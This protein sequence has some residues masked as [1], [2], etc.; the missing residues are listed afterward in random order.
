MDSIISVLVSRKSLYTQVVAV[1]KI[2][3]TD[4]DTFYPYAVTL[5]K[6]VVIRIKDEKLGREIDIINKIILGDV[7][8]VREETIAGQNVRKGIFKMEKTLPIKK[9]TPEYISELQKDIGEIKESDV[10]LNLEDLMYRLANYLSPV[11]TSSL[12]L[13]ATPVFIIPEG[14][15]EG[16]LV[17]FVQVLTLLYED[18]NNEIPLKIMYFEDYRMPTIWIDYIPRDEF[19][20]YLT[21]GANMKKNVELFET[22][23][24]NVA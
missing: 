6:D 21:R 18:I 4:E 20:G 9:P 24:Y 10:E 3:E 15:D 17:N 12:R 5:P 13:A 2:S 23:Y 8:P 22:T 1:P 14:E 16:Y 19:L 11:A 7:I